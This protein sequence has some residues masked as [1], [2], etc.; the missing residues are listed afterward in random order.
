MVV[1][2]EFFLLSTYTGT[3]I[4]NTAA[5]STLTNNNSTT[6]TSSTATNDCKVKKSTEP[7]SSA[8]SK[9]A[10]GGPPVLD[11]ETMNRVI[12]N[13]FGPS[14]ADHKTASTSLKSKKTDSHLELFVTQPAGN[15][16]RK[17]GKAKQTNEH[18]TKGDKSNDL[19]CNEKFEPNELD[20]TGKANSRSTA[21]KANDESRSNSPISVIDKLVNSNSPSACN[22]DKDKL[23][24]KPSKKF[25]A[26]KEDDDDEKPLNLSST[27]TIKASNQVIIDNLIDKLLSQGTE[28]ECEFC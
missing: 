17:G 5:A 26:S 14:S 27:T 25:G 15:S 28:G 7:A 21:K 24:V 11:I 3:Q 10:I 16:S 8:A 4:N 2:I 1:L 18:E 23:T 12:E 20:K 19:R 13:A 6:N 22:M 9:N